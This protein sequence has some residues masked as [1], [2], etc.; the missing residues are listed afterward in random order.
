MI[1][2]IT[3]TFN[4]DDEFK[5]KVFLLLK[6]V[7]YTDKPLHISV[8][9]DD[10][11]LEILS[12][13][14]IK[15]IK[16]PN[17]FTLNY[18]LTLL[19][20]CEQNNLQL[21]YWDF[22]NTIHFLNNI[23]DCI[24]N[25][26]EFDF[27]QF[28]YFHEVD[29]T[30]LDNFFNGI[31]THQ[32]LV[33]LK[34]KKPS[35]DSSIQ[36]K[37]LL[38]LF[39][40]FKYFYNQFTDKVGCS[41][42]SSGWFRDIWIIDRRLSCND[43]SFA[44]EYEDLLPMAFLSP[45]SCGLDF[46]TFKIGD[47]MLQNKL[48]SL[49]V[50]NLDQIR[51]S[52]NRWRYITML[53]VLCNISSGSQTIEKNLTSV[54][55]LIKEIFDYFQ[56]NNSIMNIEN[57]KKSFCQSEHPV[58]EMICQIIENHFEILSKNNA[59]VIF[60]VNEFS[61]AAVPNRWPPPNDLKW[62]LPDEHVPKPTPMYFNDPFKNV[63]DITALIDRMGGFSVLFNIFCENQLVALLNSL[64]A[65]YDINNIPTNIRESLFDIYM[66]S[67]EASYDCLL[68]LSSLTKLFSSSE[69]HSCS[70]AQKIRYL[71]NLVVEDDCYTKSTLPFNHLH[72]HKMLMDG[73]ISLST[74]TEHK[75]H[76]QILLDLAVKFL[77]KTK[78]FNNYF[79]I[80]SRYDIDGLDVGSLSEC[81]SLEILVL[82]EQSLYF[83]LKFLKIYPRGDLKSNQP[84]FVDL[85]VF[86]DYM[87][88][89]KLYASSED[90]YMEPL[91][92]YML[93]NEIYYHKDIDKVPM[94][95]LLKLLTHSEPVTTKTD[96][97][98][99]VL[100]LVDNIGVRALP[101]FIYRKIILYHLL[102]K[103]QLVNNEYQLRV[104]IFNLGLVSWKFHK[105]TR[106]IV[107]YQLKLVETRNVRID[108]SSP[109][110]L[111][112][113]IHS[114]NFFENLPCHMSMMEK[115]YGNIKTLIQE[116]PMTQFSRV[117]PMNTL[118]KVKLLDIKTSR[119][120]NLLYILSHNTNI[121]IFKAKHVIKANSL[122]YDMFLIVLKQL[123]SQCTQLQS[124]HLKFKLMHKHTE[125]LSFLEGVP[126][127]YP[128]V[129]LNLHYW[130]VDIEQIDFHDS[131]SLQQFS[132]VCA[133]FKQLKYVNIWN[134]QHWSE[135]MDT[136]LYMVS[137]LKSN[138]TSLKSITI[139]MKFSIEELE[140]ASHLVNVF[141]VITCDIVIIYY[142][143][144]KT[145]NNLIDNAGRFKLKEI[146]DKAIIYESI[147]NTD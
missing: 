63:K 19:S 15:V 1:N 48:S 116:I 53:Y 44:S 38:K 14:I 23:L 147:I 62:V 88:I 6:D 81:H 56:S 9:R 55:V 97:I 146:S 2:Y 66:E 77:N 3:T 92:E 8:P 135:S 120:S 35:K 109:Y 99:D 30:F 145:F 39:G 73:L 122:D 129:K 128:N 68:L 90:V 138:C 80:L 33:P 40:R 111:V 43:L 49:F 29:T 59:F 21:Q 16:E 130:R 94:P 34:D 69:K 72:G 85:W 58:D 101:D 32:L 25:D 95:T 76:K 24:Q 104:D 75:S 137:Q 27:F 46:I 18:K 28:V 93:K 50:E 60:F 133:D 22:N 83:V 65:Y 20:Q 67:D 13:E 144:P 17:S 143:K 36:Y 4:G 119:L 106:D 127:K 11:W 112:H 70:M 89:F 125:L 74:L 98:V 140:M 115:V 37:Q 126:V 121:Q 134:I 51:D 139:S 100:T 96:N 64:V 91:I 123:F 86:F 142:P 131:T 54:V 31:I 26:K 105:I 5:K 117:V 113:N 45:H 132:E 124:V 84:P 10:E 61:N 79:Y 102:E 110:S 57:Q 103:P 118:T 82:N 41:A 107:S 87:E 7:E 12:N 52:P 78:D 47:D 136:F 108:L 42:F 71:D 114:M 141:Q